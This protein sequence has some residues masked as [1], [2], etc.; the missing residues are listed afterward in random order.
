MG[1]LFSHVALLAQAKQAGV[2]FDRILTIGHQ[3]SYLSQSQ[4]QRLATRYGPQIEATA[5]AREKYV[6]DLFQSVLGASVVQSLDY[7]DFEGSE[8]VHDM[9]NPID[10]AHHEQFDVVIDG[11]SLEHIF[12]FP[13]AIANCMKLVKPGGTLFVFTMANNHTGHGFYQFSPELFFRI[14]QPE[15]GFEVR[16]IILEKHLY[17]GAELGHQ[18]QFYS[19]VDPALLKTR[20]G[21]VSK[22]PVMMMVQATKTAT[23]PLFTKPPIQ[24]DYAEA[25]QS[26]TSTA[27]APASSSVYQACR[28]FARSCY[29][30][31]PIRWQHVVDGQRQLWHYSFANKRFYQRWDPL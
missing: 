15:N 20:V 4:I 30:A 21:L 6:D 7:S 29:R 17:P 24:S 16:Q 18:R 9:N 26:P 11:G 12:N 27:A 10:A 25:Y 22:S 2:C 28:R 3:Q 13:V 8:L 5:L 31:L 14:L 23:V 1:I 19:V